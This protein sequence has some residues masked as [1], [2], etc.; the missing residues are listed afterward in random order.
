MLKNIYA[1]LSGGVGQER[2]MEIIANNLAN[3]NTVGYKEEQITFQSMDSNPWN[4]YSSVLPPAPFKMDMKELY[5][6]R[7]NEMAYVAV[8]DVRTSLVQGGLQKTGNPLDLA[9]Q[10]NG[11]F[12]V[13]TPF[14]ER[15]TRDGSF[16][17]TPDGV[18]VTKNGALVQGENGAIAGLKEGDVQILPSGEVFLGDR[19]V[20]KIK[21]VA[22]ND[23]KSVQKL[24]D[25]LFVHDGP[26]DNII[27]PTGEVTQ[28]YLESSNVNPMRNLTNM[29]VAHRS[30]EALQKAVKTHDETLQL[31]SSKVGNVDG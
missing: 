1:P 10:G 31:S 13:N 6:L 14:G 2:V 17:L 4:S 25:N 18:L 9:I 24:G 28:G 19:F 5:P 20:D 11:M 27:A 16:S 3:T 7:G 23:T 26:P 8:S 12:V 21:T 30:Y 29:I 22:F 15:Y